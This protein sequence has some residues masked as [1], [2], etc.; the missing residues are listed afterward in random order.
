MTI[1]KIIKHEGERKAE[2]TKL[3]T[4]TNKGKKRKEEEKT[5]DRE[6]TDV[7]KVQ[8]P[9]GCDEGRHNQLSKKKQ[10]E[11]ECRIKEWL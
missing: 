4:F 11:G 1:I 9:V 2:K 7:M 3:I 10:Q 5:C 8:Y 6:A